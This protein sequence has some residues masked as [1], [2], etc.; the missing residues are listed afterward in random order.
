VSLQLIV[1]EIAKALPIVDRDTNTKTVGV[2]SKIE[3]LPGI[4]TMHE[5]TAVPQMLEV[6]R[7]IGSISIDA[8]DF[9]VPFKTLPVGS[10]RLPQCDA[11]LQVSE[12]GRKSSWAMQFKRIQFLGDN[13]KNNDYGFQKLLSP[14]LKDRSLLHD[15]ES[16]RRSGL[17]DRQFVVGYSFR[18][19]MR[20]LGTARS[21]HPNHTE[22]I[23]NAEEVCLR[24]LSHE[25]NPELGVSMVDGFLQR[26]GLVLEHASAAFEGA[27]RHPCGGSGLVFGWELK[28]LTLQERAED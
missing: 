11:V 6:V 5:T 25:L 10:K 12:A 14:Y 17:G 8:M 2:R 18:H 21:L 4:P 20:L 9:E 1:S 3:Y 24:E 23:R 15:C 13:G 19:S 16:L 26:T 27:W 7:G 22:R 28:P